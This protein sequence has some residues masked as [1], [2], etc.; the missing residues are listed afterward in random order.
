LGGRQVRGLQ[1][2]VLVVGAPGA[3]HGIGAGL[4]HEVHLHAR[5]RLAGVG[6]AGRDLHLLKHVEV[7][8]A[9]RRSQRAHIGDRNAVH[10][11]RV[12]AGRRPFGDVVGLLA[13][14]RAADVDAI[15]DDAGHRLQHYPRVARA[16]NV[17]Q[18]LVGHVRRDRLTLRFHDRHFN[19]H[20]NLLA[21]PLHAEGDPQRDDAARADGNGAVEIVGESLERSLDLVGAGWQVQQVR[22]TM[23]VGG[24]VLILRSGRFDGDTRQHGARHVGDRY[25]DA[26][27]EH[28]GVH[29]RRGTHHRREH[30]GGAC[31]PHALR[32]HHFGWPPPPP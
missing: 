23:R 20:L 31:A 29:R 12:V 16:R 15:D 8:V 18:L 24:H 32:V 17:L 25:V 11:P 28:L 10:E 26:S 1:V 9:R 19:R 14:L 7:V 21:D 27:G 22:F 13:R 3:V 2:L 4:Q 6:A 30:R 5:R